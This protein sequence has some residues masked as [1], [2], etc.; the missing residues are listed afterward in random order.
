[1]LQKRRLEKES[2]QAVSMGYETEYYLLKLRNCTQ[3]IINGKP[4][5]QAEFQD[6]KNILLEKALAEID[7]SYSK[8]KNIDEHMDIMTVALVS[9]LMLLV[10]ST[11]S[12]ESCLI[13]ASFIAIIAII[14]LLAI[15]RSMAK[16]G[17]E[18]D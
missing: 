16:K 4:F 17:R 2:I 12:N 14:V 7:A 10:L 11:I 5:R 6:T 9:G 3:D 13:A 1:M 18:C 8:N 15:F